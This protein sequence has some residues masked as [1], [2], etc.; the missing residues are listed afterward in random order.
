MYSTADCRRFTIVS[1]LAH[2]PTIVIKQSADKKCSEYSSSIQVT[3][4]TPVFFSRSSTTYRALVSC[5]CFTTFSY[6]LLDLTACA[7]GLVANLSMS[8]HQ[9]QENQPLLEERN[10]VPSL[11][12]LTTNAFGKDGIED[13]FACTPFAVLLSLVILYIRSCH[14]E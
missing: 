11:W 9:V 10:L 3:R 1:I 14:Q 6:Y 8:Q 4:A 5:L 13:F 12:V 2:H 7:D